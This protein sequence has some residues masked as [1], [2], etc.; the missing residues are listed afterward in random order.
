MIL[1]SASFLL[2]AAYATTVVEPTFEVVKGKV[3]RVR[4]K[5]RAGRMRYGPSSESAC[6][7]SSKLLEKCY[8]FVSTDN[9]S[10]W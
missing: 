5:L 8:I 1:V 4:L 6:R 7:K 9:D 10:S 3:W 2:W